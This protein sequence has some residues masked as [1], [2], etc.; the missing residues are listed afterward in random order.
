MAPSKAVQRALAASCF[1]VK[2]ASASWITSVARTPWLA[3]ICL[4]REWAAADYVVRGALS[5]T[6][7]CLATAALDLI[8]RGQVRMMQCVAWSVVVVPCLLLTGLFISGFRGPTGLKDDVREARCG[9]A[10]AR[11]E[12][13]VFEGLWEIP[14]ACAAATIALALLVVVCLGS[15]CC[16]PAAYVGARWRQEQE[17]ERRAELLLLLAPFSHPGPSNVDVRAGSNTEDACSICLDEFRTGDR[18]KRLPCSRA[19]IFHVGCAACWLQRSSRC[20][21]CRTDVVELVASAAA[22]PLVASA[23]H[24]MGAAIAPSSFKVMF[25][26]ICFFSFV[27]LFCLISVV[28][29][30]CVED[31]HHGVCD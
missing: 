29:P 21:L 8:R 25:N 17:L 31:C 9:E 24:Q 7:A 22:E 4:T 27:V 15:T 5:A 3:P 23:L 26:F 18:C 16:G 20:P 14:A 1:V 10:S 11:G 13:L 12:F 2:I 19:H 30:Q 6:A 28:C